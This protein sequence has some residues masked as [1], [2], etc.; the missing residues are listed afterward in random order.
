MPPLETGRYIISNAQF[1]NVVVLADASDTF[2]VSG[3]E[4]NIKGATVKANLSV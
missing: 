1:R 2:L 3:F 4:D